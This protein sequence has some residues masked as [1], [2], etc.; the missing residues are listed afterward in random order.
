MLYIYIRVSTSE[1]AE[2]D[3]S[4]PRQKELGIQVAEEYG[5]SYKVFAEAGASASQ[6]NFDNRPQLFEVLRLVKEGIIENLFVFDQTR[7]SRNNITK[8]VISE[9]L[10]KQ[11]VHLYTHSKRFD[12]DKS[13]DALTFKILEAI[14]SY[15][16]E[17]RKARFKLG[18]VCANKKGR[19]LKGI[20]P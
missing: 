11:K 3:L 1:Q 8:A 13:E 4:M 19:Y 15:E 18:Y 20:P 9:S 5:M 17:L 14:E 12:F 6:E 2:K 7:L 16:S 10:K